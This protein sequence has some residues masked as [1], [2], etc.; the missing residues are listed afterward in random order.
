MHAGVGKEEPDTWQFSSCADAD[1]PSN[2]VA[3][4]LPS[5]K[6]QSASAGVPREQA[7]DQLE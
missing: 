2:V 5:V 3:V 7:V 6:M 1:A 4:T